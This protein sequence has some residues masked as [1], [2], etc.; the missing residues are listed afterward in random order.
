MPGY[1]LEKW[2]QA[3]S[4]LLSPLCCGLITREDIWVASDV[5]MFKEGTIEIWVSP[6]RLTICGK[7]R[8]WKTEEV[9]NGTEGMAFRVVDV[10]FDIEPCAVTAQLNGSSLEIC[11]S[12][13]HPERSA[14]KA[15]AA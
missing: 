14:A 12:K 5:S 9:A 4:E 2:R 1:E 13:A 11:V 8:G 10:P 3:E 6:R 15:S 7:P